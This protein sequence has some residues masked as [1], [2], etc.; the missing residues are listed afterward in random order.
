MHSYCRAKRV[1]YNAEQQM[2]QQTNNNEK[3][4]PKQNES[5]FS[6]ILKQNAFMRILLGLFIDCC[7]K[8]S[9][10]V[11][12]QIWCLCMMMMTFVFVVY[13]LFY[14][15]FSSQSSN[16]LIM[17]PDRNLSISTNIICY[18]INE[19]NGAL[20]I[21]LPFGCWSSPVFFTAQFS[22]WNAIHL[23]IDLYFE[24]INIPNREQNVHILRSLCAIVVIVDAARLLSM[25]D[26]RINTIIMALRTVQR[27][28]WTYIVQLMVL[29]E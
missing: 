12:V 10:A 22:H 19:P 21:L 6:H 20:A 1:M 13:V 18:N 24:M 25:C 9:S 3:K 16:Q 5:S 4:E 26:V 8:L 11:C 28:E 7:L 27:T 15:Y 14:T 2:P 29:Q 23:P 17:L